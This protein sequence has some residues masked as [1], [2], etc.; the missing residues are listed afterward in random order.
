MPLNKTG[1]VKIPS[2]KIGLADITI[3]FETYTSQP[4]S[5][6]KPTLI[7]LHGG[8]GIVDHTMYVPFWS[9]LTDVANIEFI[10]L[11]GH[12]QSGGHELAYQDT[13]CLSQ[14]ADDVV[15]YCDAKHIEHPIIAGFSFGAWIAYAY[16]IQHPQHAKKIIFVNGEPWVNVALRAEKFKARA[17]ETATKQ[18]K[19]DPLAYGKQVKQIVMDLRDIALTKKSSA[20]DTA[21]LYVEHC[22]PLFSNTPYTKEELSTCLRKN[23]DL[24]HYFDTNEYYRFDYRQQLNALKLKL[25]N[26]KQ[27]RQHIPEIYMI[28]GEYDP[29]HPA[30]GTEDA[31]NRLGEY[32]KHVVIAN[33]GDPVYRDRPDISLQI[34]KH[35]V[36]GSF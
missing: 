19:S 3:Y 24:W 36:S 29:E 27:K 20:S 35:C 14:W 2:G 34:L 9:Q 8:P 28:A 12:G 18:G 6:K 26:L 30:E 32:A 11:R 17:I 13:W 1:K 23:T 15:A 4:Y 25:G 10:D 16:L 21:Q 7:F 31:S 22:L 33:T 5:S